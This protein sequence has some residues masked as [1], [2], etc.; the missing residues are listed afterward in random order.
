MHKKTGFT[1]VELMIVVAVIS[2]LASI[3]I[4]KM[5]GARD[6]SKLE[7]CK[8]NLRHISIAMDIYANDNR[9]YYTPCTT[10]TRTDYANCAYLVPDYMKAIVYCPTGHAYKIVANYGGNGSNIPA[11]ATTV[12]NAEAPSRHTGIPNYYPRYVIGQGIV[13][14]P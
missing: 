3:I 5:T 11:G 10:S 9:G 8:A 1:M 7:A 13:E 4:P 6:K 2:V 12:D 14:R